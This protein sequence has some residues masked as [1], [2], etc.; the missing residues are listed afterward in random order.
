MN[1]ETLVLKHDVPAKVN[2]YQCGECGGI[3]VML[4]PDRPDYCPLCGEDC[5]LKP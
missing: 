2:E 3:F 5:E 1:E 4:V